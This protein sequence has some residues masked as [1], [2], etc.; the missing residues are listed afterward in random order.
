MRFLMF[1]IYLSIEIFLIAE[2]IDEMGFWA[3]VGE[4]VLSAVLGFGILKSHF[5]AL[6]VSLRG[7]VDFRISIGALVGKSI[8]CA[9]GGILLILPFILS[10]ILGVCFVV[11][12]LFFRTKIAE[13][14][15]KKGD[16]AEFSDSAN[17][18]GAE[19]SFG[20]E[21]SLKVG[22]GEVIDVEVVE[23]K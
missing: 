19:S 5:G 10:D 1:L 11:I 9:L 3:F 20:A 22:Q 2:F 14:N 23:H 6:G 21:S 17:F 12:S 4:V 8:F 13:S 15:F 7:I 16:F 18:K